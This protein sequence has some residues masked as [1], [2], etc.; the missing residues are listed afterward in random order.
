MIGVHKVEVQGFE[1]ERPTKERSKDHLYN[2]NRSA[3]FHQVSVLQSRL[4][5][6]TYSIWIMNVISVS[7]FG[8]CP[9]S[10]THV[11]LPKNLSNKGVN[12]TWCLHKVE[13]NFTPFRCYFQPAIFSS[14]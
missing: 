4:E 9:T 7:R 8:M 13:N 12:R 2:P 14:V 3:W 6:F 10:F 1:W 5:V 11:V